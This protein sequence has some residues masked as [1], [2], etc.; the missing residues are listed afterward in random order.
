MRLGLSIACYGAAYFIVTVMGIIHT[1]L[2]II[3][4]DRKSVV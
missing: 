1:C 2:N 3:V 4:L